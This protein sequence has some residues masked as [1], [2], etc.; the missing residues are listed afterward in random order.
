V[1]SKS[2][3]ERSNWDTGVAL[4]LQTPRHR[5]GPSIGA[6]QA[7]EYDANGNLTLNRAGAIEHDVDEAIVRIDGNDVVF[8]ADGQLFERAGATFDYSVHGDLASATV[9]GVTVDYVNDALHRRVAVLGETTT[10]YLYGDVEHPNRITHATGPEGVSEYFYGSY[11]HVV[12]LGRDGVSYFIASDQVG[13]PRFVVDAAGT[14]VKDITHDAWSH[15]ITDSAPEFPLHVGF[16]S[17]LS[18][19][20]TGWTTFWMRDYDLEIGRFTTMDPALFGAKRPNMY[21]YADNNP[22]TRVDPTGFISLSLDGHYSLIRGTLGVADSDG[23]ISVCAGASAGIALGAGLGFDLFG[24]AENTQSFSRNEASFEILGI[25]VS[26]SNTLADIDCGDGRI[27][28]DVIVNSFDNSFEGGGAIIE[29]IKGV[30]AGQLKLGASAGM[31]TVYGGCT[32][33]QIW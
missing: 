32:R 1:T 10:S 29:A 3:V 11:G 13:T 25:G 8:N 23:A 24:Q 14:V 15:R 2:S 26:G 9:G 19:V 12:A 17:G 5:W 30:G 16:A 31:R 7:F 18:D 27:L 21:A 4:V 33:T 22:S 20:A 6:T 28:E